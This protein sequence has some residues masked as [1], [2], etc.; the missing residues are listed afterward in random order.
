LRVQLGVHARETYLLYIY[1]PVKIPIPTVRMILQIFTALDAALISSPFSER[2]R[3]LLPIKAGTSNLGVM[4]AVASPYIKGCTVGNVETAPLQ[5]EYGRGH[6]RIM[7]K[8]LRPSYLS[9]S[10]RAA[11]LLSFSIMRFTN[12]DR[13]VRDTMK[14][15][16]DPSTVAE[17]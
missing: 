9:V 14:E 13:I 10:A 7:H 11:N 8:S 6:R 17:A 2:I 5:T 1:Q 4:I 16:V 12:F 15:H 3:I